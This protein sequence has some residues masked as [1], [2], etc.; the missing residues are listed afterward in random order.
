MDT[1]NI[2][3]PKEVLLFPVEFLNGLENPPAVV[4]FL[5]EK[6]RFVQE[7]IVSDV[8][9]DTQSGRYRVRHDS[10]YKFQL[11]ASR[12]GKLAFIV[13]V[14]LHQM[15]NELNCG[16]ILTYPMIKDGFERMVVATLKDNNAHALINKLSSHSTGL[17]KRSIHACG[18]GIALALFLGF[19]EASV[20]AIGLGGLLH[21]YGYL[22]DPLNH[23][24]SGAD[25]LDM[26]FFPTKNDSTAISL[27]IVAFHHAMRP[28]ASPHVNC[29]KIAIHWCSHP[30][31]D[32]H[33]RMQAIHSRRNM[34]S[35]EIYNGFRR[36]YDMMVARKTN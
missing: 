25:G 14:I 1:D 28:H 27:N 13:A 29:G 9:F 36:L 12:E 33:E 15:R 2:T 30:R 32:I 7:E 24:A 22:I 26:T 31:Q 17:V 34:Y 6:N 16:D 21:E 11:T 19:E 20:K 35:E 18:L 3:P 5:D 4:Q 8:V 10:P 23:A